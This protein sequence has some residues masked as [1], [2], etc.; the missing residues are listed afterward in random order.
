VHA[1]LLLDPASERELR[2]ARTAMDEL[3]ALAVELGGAISGEHGV[4]ALKRG[5]LARQWRPGALRVHEEIKRAL[6]PKGL[7]NPGKKLAR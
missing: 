2:A 3:F 4:G 5:Q 7:L 6:D 1:N